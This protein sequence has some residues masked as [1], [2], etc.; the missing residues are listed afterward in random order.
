MYREVLSEADDETRLLIP[1]QRRKTKMFII[2]VLN[3]RRGISIMN[4]PITFY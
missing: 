1:N 2:I 3:I 4:Q